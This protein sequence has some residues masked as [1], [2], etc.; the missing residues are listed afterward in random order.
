M[1]RVKKKSNGKETPA[2]L[3]DII[4]N[5]TSH[6]K[7]KKKEIHKIVKDTNHT[8]HSI[9]DVVEDSHMIANSANDKVH[10]QGEQ[11]DRIGN[12]VAD[13]HLTVKESK[14]KVKGIHSFFSAMKIFFTPKCLQAQKE[15]IDDTVKHEIQTQRDKDTKRKKNSGKSGKRGSD[16]EIQSPTVTILFDSKTQAIAQDTFDT[17][18]TVEDV[19]GDLNRLARETNKEVRRQNGVLDQVEELVDETNKNLAKTNKV[20]KKYLNH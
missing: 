1:V 2:L 19:L 13:T 14:S 8:A 17:L 11:I 7:K 5:T 4:I 15:E 10:E 16:I 6:P 9:L 3:P 12:V 20:A 18:T